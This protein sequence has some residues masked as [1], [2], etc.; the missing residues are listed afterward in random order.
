LQG[1]AD[2]TLHSRAQPVEGVTYARK[3][4]KAEAPIDWRR[5]AVEIDRQVRAL[6]RWPV[7]ETVVS[8]P[9]TGAVERLLIHDSRV[10][11]AGHA[12]SGRPGYIIETDGRHGE[13]FIRVQ[14][15]AGALDL[16]RLQRPGGQSLAASLFTRGPRALG[17]SMVLG[18]AI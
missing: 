8:D 2:G 10:A 1:L 4:E 16:L 3:L 18:G 12:A 14:C 17:P 6:Q 9:G 5:P 13:G 7:A 11:P 15:G